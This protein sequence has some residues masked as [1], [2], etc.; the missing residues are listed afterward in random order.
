[1]KDPSLP[2]CHLCQNT[3]VLNSLYTTTNPIQLSANDIIGIIGNITQSEISKIDCFDHRFYK[4]DHV[5]SLHHE[6]VFHILCLGDNS[7]KD[8]R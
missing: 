5:T 3:H 6:T 4:A 7:G 2:I 1:M 8:V